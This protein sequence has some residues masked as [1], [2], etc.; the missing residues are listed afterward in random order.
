MKNLDHLR[1]QHAMG[2]IEV[3]K[4]YHGI[5]PVDTGVV[6]TVFR[7]S[8]VELEHHGIASLA[9]VTALRKK[10]ESDAAI[11]RLINRLDEAESMLADEG[12]RIIT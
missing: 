10:Y 8:E 11:T 2:R 5:V 1:G 7:G 6:I 9:E 3:L 12:L 4:E